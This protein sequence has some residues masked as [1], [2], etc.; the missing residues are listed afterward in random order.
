M[1]KGMRGGVR[2][3]AV[4]RC[5]HAIQTCGLTYNVGT[6]TYFTTLK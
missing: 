4:K 6:T 3:L 2:G 5:G 1:P